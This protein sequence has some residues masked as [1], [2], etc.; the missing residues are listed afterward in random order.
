MNDRIKQHVIKY[1]KKQELYKK[2]TIFN[3]DILIEEIT[4]S[5]N[6]YRKEVD[7]RRWW[8]EYLYVVE[9]DGMILGYYDAEA[10]GDM[11]VWELGYEF[12][13]SGIHEMKMVEIT[14]IAYE[15]I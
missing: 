6:L 8:N 4:E 7:Q 2:D 11:S 15:P 14:I 10:T 1:C 13:K 5:T 3:D 9:I 12:D